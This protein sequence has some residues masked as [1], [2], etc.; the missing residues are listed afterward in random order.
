MMT[1][2]TSGR[3]AAMPAIARMAVAASSQRQMLPHQSTIVSCSPICGKRSRKGR[4]RGGGGAGGMPKGITMGG[5][6]VASSGHTVQQRLALAGAGAEHEVGVTQLKP[7]HGGGGPQLA[8]PVS[9][10]RERG[11]LELLRVVL[12]GDRHRPVDAA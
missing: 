6:A 2:L 3:R 9:A 10:A 11:Q 5:G 7:A 1:S 12:V 8:V 4:L